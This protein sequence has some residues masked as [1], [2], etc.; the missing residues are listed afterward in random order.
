MKELKN[1]EN[2]IC[3]AMFLKLKLFSTYVNPRIYVGWV[4]LKF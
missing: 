4:T 1:T 2:F 3:N